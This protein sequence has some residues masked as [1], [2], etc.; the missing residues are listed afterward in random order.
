MEQRVRSEPGTQ[1][2][3]PSA[4]EQLA[5]RWAIEIR[6]SLLSQEP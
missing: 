6:D 3:Y 1:G 2:F 5:L 4:G